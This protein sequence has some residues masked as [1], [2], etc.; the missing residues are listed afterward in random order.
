MQMVQKHRCCQIAD[1]PGCEKS[2][3]MLHSVAQESSRMIQKEARGEEGCLRKEA[4]MNTKD[5]PRR[6][7]VQCD[8]VYDGQREKAMARPWLPWAVAAVAL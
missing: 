5:S 4:K 1:H 3:R 7:Q 2:S 6:G 8:R